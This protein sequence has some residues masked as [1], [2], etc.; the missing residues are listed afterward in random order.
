[1]PEP[2]VSEMYA[3]ASRLSALIDQGLSAMREHATSYADAEAAYRK[4]KAKA[5]VDAPDGMLAKEK[6]AWVDSTTADL[7]RTRDV[8]EAMK[9]AALEA[10][11]SRRSQ[12]SA[13]QTFA[14][15]HREEAGLART[16]PGLAA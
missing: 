1:M 11:R 3:E 4:A 15:A 9:Q 12:L 6:E 2:T 14:N 10:V 13:V 8:A 5:W 7:R 16:G